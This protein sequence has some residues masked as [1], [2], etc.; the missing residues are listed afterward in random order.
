[1]NARSQNCGTLPVPAETNTAIQNQ[2]I[3]GAVPAADPPTL[4]AD[5]SASAVNPSRRRFIVNS[6]VSVASVA[7]ALPVAAPAIAAGGQNVVIMELLSPPSPRSNVWSGFVVD[8][9]CQRWTFGANRLGELLFTFREDRKSDMPAERI[10]WLQGEP[11]RE[12]ASVVHRAIVARSQEPAK[13]HEPDPIFAAI[14]EHRRLWDEEYNVSTMLDEAEREKGRAPIPLIAWRTYSHIGGSEIERA[15]KEFLRHRVAKP[16]KIEQEYR[17][18]KARERAVWRAHRQWYKK[19]GLAALKTQCDQVRKAEQKALMALTTIRP[20]TTA[21]A[22]ALVMYVRDDMKDGDHPWQERALAN[23]ARALLGMNDE[24]LPPPAEDRHDLKL[25]NA[26]TNMRESEYAI[27]ALNKKY[28][29][30]AD[31]RDDYQHV[32]SERDVALAILSTRRAR[33]S[34]GMIAK[35]AALSERR[36][37]EDY[38][39]HGEIATSLAADVLRYFGK[40]IVLEA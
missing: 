35:A 3:V 26:V 29:D 39:R 33:S 16:R 37:I 20:T 6:L 27:D 21:G 5:A 18:A 12:L 14:E 17:E 40:R 8:G 15:R 38:E 13:E 32:E 28:G 10:A 34:N 31:S 23:A 7:S 36:V 2:H 24:C 22:G 1:M 30:D 4:S 11:P 25:S 9:N 19:N